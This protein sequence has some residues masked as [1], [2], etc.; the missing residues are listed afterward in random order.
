[1]L[2]HNVHL[3]IIAVG[4]SAHFSGAL[5]AEAIGVPWPSGWGWQQN[6]GKQYLVSYLCADVRLLDFFLAY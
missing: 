6:W 5:C 3:R 2:G 4:A 1:M